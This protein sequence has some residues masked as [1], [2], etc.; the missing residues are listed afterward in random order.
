MS[1]VQRTHKAC[2]TFHRVLSH[3]FCAWIASPPSH[4][5]LRGLVFGGFRMV[6]NDLRVEAPHLDTVPDTPLFNTKAVVRRTK[7]PAP[8]LRAWERR[9]GILTPQRAE[10]AYRLYSERDIVIIAWLRDRVE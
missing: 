6:T 9:Y 3:H 8:T 5:P 4:L 7:V 10:N 1:A 2:M